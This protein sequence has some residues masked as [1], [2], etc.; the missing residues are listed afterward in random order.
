MKVVVLTC[1]KYRWLVPIF[2]HFYRKYWPDNPYQVEVIAEHADEYPEVPTYY[3]NGAKWSQGIIDYIKH[4]PPTDDKFLLTPEDYIL[5]SPVDTARIKEAESL[6]SG[7]VGCVRLNE[8]DKYFAYTNDIKGNEGFKSY[9]LDK[10]YSMSMQAAIWQKSF[11]L[12]VL[13]ENEDAWEAELLGS[14]RLAN[15]T[16]KWWVYWTKKAIWDYQAGGFMLRGRPRIEVVKWTVSN[17]IEEAC[18]AGSK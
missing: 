6:C 17:L 1:D 8:P 12:D 14:K 10:P 18:R 9:P 16:H 2:F 15:M 7:N 4:F 3:T 13:R 11:L 5:K